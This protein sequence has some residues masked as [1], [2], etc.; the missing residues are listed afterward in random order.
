MIRANTPVR[1]LPA[2]QDAGDDAY[3]WVTTADEDGG[4]VTIT[5]ANHPMAIPLVYVV[6]TDWIAPITQ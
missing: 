1:I 2:Y 6:R 4:R 3:R 5:P